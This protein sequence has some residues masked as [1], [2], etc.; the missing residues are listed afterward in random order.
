MILE[1]EEPDETEDLAVADVLIIA[2]TVADLV[3]AMVV[4]LIVQAGSDG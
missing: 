1:E 2:A 3:A 4:A